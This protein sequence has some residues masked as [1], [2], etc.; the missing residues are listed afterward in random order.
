M[1]IVLLVCILINASALAQ[2][3]PGPAP[4]PSTKPSTAPAT[5]IDV[6]TE[7]EK[8]KGLIGQEASVRGKVVDVFV[9]RS[10]S[11]TILNFFE[12]SAR[13]DFNVV[14][15]KANI[16]AVNA[17]HNGDV[18]A[19]VKGQTIVVTGTVSEYRGNPQIKVEKPEQIKIE[20]PAAAKDAA[21]DAAKEEKKPE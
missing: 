21:K 20:P 9:P 12:G 17:A 8:L 4:A 16:D 3:A 19:A 2:D 5:P 11:V 10:G 14:I 13:R 6:A 15:D 1:R 18:A 7:M